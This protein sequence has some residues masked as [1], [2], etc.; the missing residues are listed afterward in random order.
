MLLYV[1]RVNYSVNSNY[2]KYFAELYAAEFMRFGIF[3]PHISESCGATYRRNSNM[4][5]ALQNT[6]GH[7]TNSE[8][9][10]QV[11]A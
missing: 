3:P 9:S 10:V 1:S 6:S 5:S 11:D 7:Q 2:T 4:F 8:N